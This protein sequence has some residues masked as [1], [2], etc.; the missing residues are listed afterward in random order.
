MGYTFYAADSKT[1][2]TTV[3]LGTQRGAVE[4]TKWTR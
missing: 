4:F 2:I 3:T 1:L